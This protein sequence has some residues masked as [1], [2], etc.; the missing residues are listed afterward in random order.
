[1]RKHSKTKNTKKLSVHALS[2]QLVDSKTR[3]IEFCGNCVDAKN[4]IQANWKEIVDLGA[5]RGGSFVSMPK[6]IAIEES[7]DIS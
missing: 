3:I 6:V 1:M 2:L 7:V 5:G 4:A